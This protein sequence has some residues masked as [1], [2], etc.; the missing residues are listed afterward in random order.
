MTP[1]RPATG[2]PDEARIGQFL[3][4]ATYV[5]VVLLVVGVVVLLAAG[6]SPLA[7][8]PDLDLSLVPAWLIHLEPAGFLWA[9]LLAVVAT[10]IVRVALAAVV[11]TRAGDRQMVLVALGILAVV[12]AGVIAARAGTV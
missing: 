4:A 1:G 7:G 3:I 6:V 5:S 2:L 12:L 10:P 8:G 11:F 9:G